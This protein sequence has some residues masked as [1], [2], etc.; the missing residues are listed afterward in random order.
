MPRTCDWPQKTLPIA[1]RTKEFLPV[2]SVHESVLLFCVGLFDVLLAVSLAV[3]RTRPKQEVSLAMQS[4]V[5]E[6]TQR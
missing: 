1:W 5:I 4:V 2:M 6:A 3:V